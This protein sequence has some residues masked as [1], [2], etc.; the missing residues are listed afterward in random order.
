MSY[1]Q[2]GYFLLARPVDH[3]NFLTGFCSFSRFSKGLISTLKLLSLYMR[4]LITILS[5]ISD[6]SQRSIR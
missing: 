6:N 2:E 3:A 5:E 1:L 4:V